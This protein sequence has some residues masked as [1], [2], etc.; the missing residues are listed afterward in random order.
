[1][2]IQLSDA[3]LNINK[4]MTSLLTNA[5][6]ASF[7]LSIFILNFF[8]G[9]EIAL[10]AVGLAIFF[11]FFFG[12]WASSM[13]GTFVKT[14]A[15][16]NSF[17]KILV[18]GSVIIIVRTLEM[19]INEDSFLTTKLVCSFA[20]ACEL[21]SVMAN[22]LIINPDLPFISLLRKSLANEI[23]DKLHIDKEEVEEEL[24]KRVQKKNK[25]NNQK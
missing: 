14:K 9:Y 7:S 2:T 19:G 23:A 17:V 6:G 22:I 25:K 24:N 15:W 20:T 18:Y 4:N 21:W 12:V 10:I 1:M 3:I 11:D 16:G 8:S 13:R 5:V